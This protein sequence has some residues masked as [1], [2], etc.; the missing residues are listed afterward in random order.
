[1]A[2]RAFVCWR[3]CVALCARIRRQ[4]AWRIPIF[5]DLFFFD[6]SGVVA[7]TT[8]SFDFNRAVAS[9]QPSREFAAH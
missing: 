3:W 5:F 2:L 4:I 7:A 1:V 8:T 6:V 9:S